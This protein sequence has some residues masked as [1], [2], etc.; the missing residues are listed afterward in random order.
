MLRLALIML[1][2][3]GAGYTTADSFA[4]RVHCA[5]IQLVQA[6]LFVAD[7]PAGSPRK[8]FQKYFFAGTKRA[9]ALVYAC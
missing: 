8:A 1:E 9:S 6:T 2:E 7:G 5:R 4:G 3:D